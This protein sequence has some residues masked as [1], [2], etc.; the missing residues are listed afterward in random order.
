MLFYVVSAILDKGKKKGLKVKK[1]KGS[2]MVIETIY[3]EENELVVIFANGDKVKLGYSDI[4]E[5]TEYTLNYAA[6]H[7]VDSGF[8]IVVPAISNDKPPPGTLYTALPFTVPSSEIRAKTD[9]A[10]AADLQ[11]LASEQAKYLKK[12]KIMER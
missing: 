11:K 3:D 12:N 8:A 10:F 2:Y 1:R 4:T 5:A 7:I 6:A 9:P